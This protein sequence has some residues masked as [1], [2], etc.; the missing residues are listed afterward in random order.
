MDWHIVLPQRIS[1]RDELPSAPLHDAMRHEI[2]SP[3]WRGR[4]VGPG[5]GILTALPLVQHNLPVPELGKTLPANRQ[6]VTR[7]HRRQHAVAGGL[8][9]NLSEFASNLR[10][11]LTMSRRAEVISL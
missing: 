5:E 7:P 6:K 3:S 11:Q 9:S 4:P 8:E 1:P 10:E 2:P